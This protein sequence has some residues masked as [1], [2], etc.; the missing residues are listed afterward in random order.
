MTNSQPPN[1]TGQLRTAEEVLCEAY[2]LIEFNQSSLPEHVDPVLISAMHEYAAQF[3]KPTPITAS[4]GDEY[5]SLFKIAA[6]VISAYKTSNLAIDEATVLDGVIA[7]IEW[8]AS[9]P[10]LAIAIIEERIKEL[11]IGQQEI[12]YVNRFKRIEDAKIIHEL[13][14]L[15]KLITPIK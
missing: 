3:Q 7:G 15:L 9:Q 10:N 14:H 2:N 1:N 4:E 5:D 8:Q 12:T 13:K 6:E 11:S